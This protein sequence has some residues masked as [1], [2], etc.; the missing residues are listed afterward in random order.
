[1]RATRI[2]VS[3]KLPSLPLEPATPNSGTTR[4]TTTFS[5]AKRASALNLK[6]AAQCLVDAVAETLDGGED[7]VGGLRPF[8][9]LGIPVVLFDEGADVG[10]ELPGRGM[11]APLELL[12]RQ[13]GEPALHLID[14]RGRG[15]CEMGVM[16]RASRQP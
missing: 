4:R 1:M 3:T 13:F 6:F 8:E 11:H 2:M 10:F 9:G 15:R 12:A 7:V 14:P 5:Q 16:A